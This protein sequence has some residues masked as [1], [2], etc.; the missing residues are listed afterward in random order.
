MPSFFC[1]N[2]SDSLTLDRDL[3]K[4]IRGDLKESAFRCLKQNHLMVQIVRIFTVVNT[5]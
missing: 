2:P 3:D 4:V 1:S 5:I